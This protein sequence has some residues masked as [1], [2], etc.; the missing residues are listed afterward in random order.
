MNRTP[1]PNLAFGHG[2]ARSVRH[3]TDGH[4]SE[5]EVG[6][7]PRAPCGAAPPLVSTAACFPIAGP[8]A[9]LPRPAIAAVLTIFEGQ[10]IF[11]VIGGGDDLAHHTLFRLRRGSRRVGP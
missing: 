7:A 5:C 9:P 8:H 4:K 3:T 6:A 1:S 11:R 10:A 2:R